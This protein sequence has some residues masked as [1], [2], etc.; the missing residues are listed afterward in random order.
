MFVALEQARGMAMLATT[1]WP[2][3]DA[4]ERRSPEGE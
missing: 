3:P 2:S 1:W 4:S